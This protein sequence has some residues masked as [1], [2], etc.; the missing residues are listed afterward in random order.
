MDTHFASKSLVMLRTDVESG[1]FKLPL[2]SCFPPMIIKFYLRVLKD[3]WQNSQ[4]VSETSKTT[5]LEN[6]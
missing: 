5:K 1:I 3:G 4:K 6:F 2:V